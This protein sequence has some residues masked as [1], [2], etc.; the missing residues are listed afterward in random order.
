VSRLAT[1]Q[2]AGGSH[3]KDIGSSRARASLQRGHASLSRMAWKI[4][5][6][7]SSSRGPFP[8]KEREKTMTRNRFWQYRF[9]A[10]RDSEMCNSCGITGK[11]LVIDHIDG[12]RQ[13]EN[14]V[15]LRLLCRSC[16]RK[17]LIELHSSNSESEREN[18]SKE[19]AAER[20]SPEQRVAEDK[21]GPYFNWLYDNVDRDGGLTF[22]DA[23]YEGADRMDISPI[24]ARRYLL[25]KLATTFKLGPGPRGH[26]LIQWRSG[27]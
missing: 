24:T 9:L 25:K 11:E 1:A 16:N 23:I 18:I 14:P 6:S 17:N 13:N 8:V 20:M 22:W 27:Q 19:E 15:N 10:Q 7:S 2:K 21:Q 12:N 5:L 3:V 26:K 4:S